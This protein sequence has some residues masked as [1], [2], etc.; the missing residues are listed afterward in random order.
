MQTLKHTN[1]LTKK[2]CQELT[3]ILLNKWVRPFT[4]PITVHSN[5]FN[6]ASCNDQ[7]AFM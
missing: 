3:D 7:E 5:L 4:L 6:E 2:H 1:T